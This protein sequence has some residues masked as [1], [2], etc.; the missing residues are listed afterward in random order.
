MA[1]PRTSELQGAR[2][3]LTEPNDSVRRQILKVSALVLAVAVLIGGGI[4]LV[5]V[6]LLNASGVLPKTAPTTGTTAPVAPTTDRARNHHKHRHPSGAPSESPS[7]GGGQ[8]PHGQ[9]VPIRL[10]AEPARVGVFDRVTLAGRYPDSGQ[11][12]LQVQRR[13]F[14]A[15]VDFPTSATVSAGTFHTYVQLGRTGRNSL[16][17]V[18]PGTGRISNTVDVFVG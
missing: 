8:H 4:A 7:P 1:V 17:V 3:V 14:G 6:T 5:S 10:T 15:W 11:A 2:P 9:Q 16:R 13:E 12:T 18:D